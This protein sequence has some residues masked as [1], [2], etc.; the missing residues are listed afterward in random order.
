MAR[1][2]YPTDLTDAEWA[3]LEP[4]VPASKPGGR[5]PKHARRELVD[6]MLYV[7]RGGIAWRLLPHEFPP[8]QTV[9][10]DFRL[11]RRDG[12]WERILTAL[13]ER[14]R[15]RVGRQPTPSAAILD[16]QTAQMTEQGGPRG[17]DAGKKIRGR[18]RQTL[19]DTDGRIISARVHPADEPD[20][21]GARPLLEAVRD[22]MPRLA[23]L[24]VDGGYKSR[25][26]TWTHETLGWRVEAVR[27]P[28]AHRRGGPETRGCRVL[29]RRWVVER[30]FAWLGRQRRLSKDDEG[31][32]A[33]EEA[34]ISLA[35]TRLLLAR[36]A[37]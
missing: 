21:T 31:L 28:G 12:T 18:K 16:S 11:W 19:V 34:W 30:T 33:T 15:V 8:W 3:L 27:P 14:D 22:R 26:A 23:L 13:R 24:W 2:P 5:P 29:P 10:H 37:S 25:F 1:R 6:A 35:M 20:G 7:L 32:A 9:Y 36:L 17:Y 4:L